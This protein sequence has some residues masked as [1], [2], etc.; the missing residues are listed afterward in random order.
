MTDAFE[1]AFAVIAAMGGGGFIVLGLS[2]WI[3]KLW[4]ERLMA[5]DREVHAETLERLRYDL[6]REFDAMKD[7]LVRRRELY[8]RTVRAMRVFLAA[9]RG[10]S[11]EEKRAFLAAYDTCF[12]WASDD[13]LQVLRDFIDLQIAHARTR[14]PASQPRMQELYG[15]CLAA[16]RRDAG[17][18][19]TAVEAKDYRVVSFGP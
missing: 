18:P 8:D 9:T 17:F 3:G 15:E 1:T 12:L 11:D 7:V 16:M 10:A 13:V 19:E 2:S 4:A 14:D 6:A 5:R